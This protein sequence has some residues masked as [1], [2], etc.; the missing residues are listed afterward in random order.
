MKAEREGQRRSLKKQH[1]SQQK[2]REASQPPPETSP[3]PALPDTAV[4]EEHR[5][6]PMAPQPKAEADPASPIATGAP[7]SGSVPSPNPG[8]PPAGASGA[9]HSGKRKPTFAQP[10]R[11][12]AHAN[13]ADCHDKPASLD[14]LHA[15]DA[16]LKVAKRLIELV[17]SGTP[18][19]LSEGDSLP[20]E[21]DR[22][23]LIEEL[24]LFDDVLAIYR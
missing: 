9:P 24:S 14:S 4:A 22:K 5:L 21:D 18:D 12:R 20:S 7:L 13:G 8:S 6:H 17:D 1:A 3:A 11:K 16:A 15:D 2:A 10:S 19:V 23:R